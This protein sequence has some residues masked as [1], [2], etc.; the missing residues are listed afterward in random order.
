MVRRP[1]VSTRTDTL[2][3]YTTLFRSGGVWRF[4]LRRGGRG[5]RQWLGLALEEVQHVLL[6][7][8]AVLAARRN[9]RRIETLLFHQLA[10]R[11][12]KVANGS[13]FQEGHEVGLGDLAAGARRRGGIELLGTVCRRCRRGGLLRGSALQRRR[14]G[15]QI[16][17][18]H[19]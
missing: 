6:R 11:R 13:T 14:G 10:H 19:V 9:N 12:P 5:G 18:A 16:G 4:R 7:E 3:P 8:A 2:V 1:R 15:G 17:R